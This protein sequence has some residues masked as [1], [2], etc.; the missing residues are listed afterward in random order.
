MRGGLFTPQS[1]KTW[2]ISSGEKLR[3]ALKKCKVLVGAK[4]RLLAATTA[5]RNRLFES[6]EGGTNKVNY[7]LIGYNEKI[8]SNE[9]I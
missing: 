3:G 4:M 7:Q 2:H 9:L 8:N 1:E 5:F 6:A